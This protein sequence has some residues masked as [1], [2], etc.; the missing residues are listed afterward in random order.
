MLAVRILASDVAK[1]ASYQL[2][3]RRTAV[4]TYRVE[5]TQH[6]QTAH[7]MTMKFVLKHKNT[8]S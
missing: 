8:S 4:A 3:S 2:N 7:L 6:V 5:M 1:L